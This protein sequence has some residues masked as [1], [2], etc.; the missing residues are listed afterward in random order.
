M[1]KKSEQEKKA[2][3]EGCLKVKNSSEEFLKCVLPKGDGEQ[4]P[5][6]DGSIGRLE[7]I[8]GDLVEQVT[9]QEAFVLRQIQ[10]RKNVLTGCLEYV[11]FEESA[12]EVWAIITYVRFQ[13]KSCYQKHRVQ[14]LL[15][16]LLIQ[17][18]HRGICLITGEN[19]IT[20][21]F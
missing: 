7:I 13:I 20:I 2:V 8:V 3:E 10:L 5:I 12:Q 17:Y 15:S 9:S 16:S 6:I 4:T 18:K 21:M 14:K 11:K 19:L 1:L